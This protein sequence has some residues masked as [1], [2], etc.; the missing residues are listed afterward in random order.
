MVSKQ[1]QLSDVR[2]EGN[3]RGHRWR[4]GDR[5]NSW[6]NVNPKRSRYE[7]AMGGTEDIRRSLQPLVFAPLSPHI[8]SRLRQ[9]ESEAVEMTCRRR[10]KAFGNP[11]A[12]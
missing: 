11:C 4:R 3:V 9:D 5:E 6:S 12:T 1:S 10:P 2:A 8:P 7:G